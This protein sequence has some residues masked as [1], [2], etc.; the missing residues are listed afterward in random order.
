MPQLPSRTPDIDI[1]KCAEKVGG[2]MELILLAAQR[3]RDVRNKHLKGDRDLHKNFAT[4]AL[5]DIQDGTIGADYKTQR[6][7]DQEDELEN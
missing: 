7:I 4:E 2:K 3:A 5:L 1:D 6:I